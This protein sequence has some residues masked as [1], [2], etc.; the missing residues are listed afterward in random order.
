MPKTIKLEPHLTSEELEN[1]YRKAH[2]PVLRTHYQILW[3]ISE[4]KPPA[5]GWGAPEIPKGLVRSGGE[6]AETPATQVPR[7]RLSPGKTKD[8]TPHTR[9]LQPLSLQLLC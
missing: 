6:H 7:S 5:R 3:L 1:R 2:D 8:R 4:G 9:A